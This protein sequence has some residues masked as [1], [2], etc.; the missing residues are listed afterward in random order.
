MYSSHEEQRRVPHWKQSGIETEEKGLHELNRSCQKRQPWRK[1]ELIVFGKEL[2][3]PAAASTIHH[4][5]K[6]TLHRVFQTAGGL[7]PVKL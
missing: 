7:V 2:L 5:S 6:P 1:A 4:H 3:H